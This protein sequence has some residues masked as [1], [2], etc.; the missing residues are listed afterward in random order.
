MD[1]FHNPSRRMLDLQHYYRHIQQTISLRQ[2]HL[3][4]LQDLLW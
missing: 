3:D 2:L 4:L 1:A